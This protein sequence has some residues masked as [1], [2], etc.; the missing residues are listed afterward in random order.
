MRQQQEK[1]EEQRETR[2]TRS[3]SR[4]REKSTV[5]EIANSTTGRSRARDGRIR[6][7]YDS[8][9]F[10]DG[11]GTRGS[12]N[13]FRELDR[14]RCT[15]SDITSKNRYRCLICTISNGSVAGRANVGDGPLIHIV[16]SIV[17]R[18][19]LVHAVVASLLGAIDHRRR[20][21]VA[22]H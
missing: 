21:R 16:R 5:E 9:H 11:L 14:E 7:L 19:I 10:G 15:T 6:L 2:T 18:A 20:G 1:L 4:A 12:K 22:D 3:R 17:C 8:D 13:R